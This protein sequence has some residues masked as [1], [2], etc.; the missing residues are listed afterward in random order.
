M[1]FIP[2]FSGSSGNSSYIESGGVRLLIDAGL[3]GKM[4][5]DALYD[6]GVRPEALNGILVTHDHIDHTRSVGVLSRKYNLPVYANEGTFRVMAPIVRDIDP[7]NV[8]LFKTGEDFYIGEMNITPFKTPHDAAESVGFTF[9]HA[10]KKLCYM[11]D[12]GCF[13]E[14]MFSE[15]AG[16]R[17]V[18]IEANHDIVMLKNGPYPYHLKQRILSESGHLSNENCGKALVRLYGTG[19]RYAVLAH[20][21]KENNTEE[22]AFAAVTAELEKAGIAD[23]RVVVAKRDRV[24]GIFDI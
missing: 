10:G 19:V 18:F 14:S 20:L 5:Q 1:R 13:R 11:T 22:T 9:S 4:V 23:M 3:T 6:V 7:R 12:I 8:R 2:L 24:T 15:A 21:S 16:S 17:L